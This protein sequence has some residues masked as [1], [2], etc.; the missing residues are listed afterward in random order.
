MYIKSEFKVGLFVFLGLLI[1]FVIVFSISDFSLKQGYTFS[2]RFNFVNGLEVSAPVRL[3]GVNVGEVKNIM[4]TNNHPPVQVLL[5]VKK[6]VFI[7][8]NS[9]VYIS[10]LGLLG[11]KYI[12]ISPGDSKTLI[13]N[14]EVII[15]CDPISVQE[16]SQLGKKTI[17]KID[18]MITNLEEIISDKEIRGGVKDIVSNSKQ[19]TQQLNITTAKANQIL[20]SLNLIFAR[21]NNG[22]GTIGKF[23]TNDSL[24]NEIEEL[25]QDVKRH[26]WKLFRKTKEKKKKK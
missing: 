19:L 14:G 1:F 21:I 12:E 15:G 4:V 26:P 3:A 7:K 25:I 20:N 6:G 23:I 24:Y 18:K 2:V 5:W 8:R 17:R 9:Q 16:F 13:K 10:S 22:E 11:E